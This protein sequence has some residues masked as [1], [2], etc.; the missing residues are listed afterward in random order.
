MDIYPVPR[1]GGLQIKLSWL[2]IL[3]D[4]TPKYL[5]SWPSSKRGIHAGRDFSDYFTN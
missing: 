4:F 5:V 1:A 2:F 3:A